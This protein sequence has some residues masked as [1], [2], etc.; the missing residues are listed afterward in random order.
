MKK[1]RTQPTHKHAHL[2][3]CF[4]LEFSFL[5]SFSRSK[6]Y[7]HSF[8]KKKKKTKEKNEKRNMLTWLAIAKKKVGRHA[9]YV[10]FFGPSSYSEY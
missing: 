9:H 5:F 6:V 8:S 4:L 2:I 10:F 3:K 1:E 7:K